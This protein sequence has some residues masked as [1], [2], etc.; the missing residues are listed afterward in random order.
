M[1]QQQPI[2]EGKLLWLE[3][4]AVALDE[5]HRL[6]GLLAALGADGSAAMAARTRIE[7]VTTEI[8]QL[9]DR[10]QFLQSR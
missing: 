5:A 2:S 8:R 9:R 7:P 4:L 3:Q 6:C 1:D 10:R